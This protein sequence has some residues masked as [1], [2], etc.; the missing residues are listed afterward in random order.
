MTAAA[1]VRAFTA[2]GGDF[3]YG[4]VLD[5]FLRHGKHHVPP[6]LLDA[7]AGCPFDPVLVDVLLD[8]FDKRYDY[9]SYLA[10]PLLDRAEGDRDRLVA[11][12]LD[13]AIAFEE[14]PGSRLPDL[15]PA[16]T[17]KRVRHLR[18][19]RPAL[20]VTP[21]PAERLLLRCT[22]LPVATVHDE[23]LFIRVL[24]AFELTFAQIVTDLSAFSP[25]AL[26]LAADRLRSRG[27]LWSALA[28]MSVEAFQRFRRYT[29]GASAIQ[30]RHYKLMESLAR[31]PDA[32]RLASEAYL[33]VPEVRVRVLAGGPT[34]DAVLTP[35]RATHAA[36]TDFAE[37]LTQWRR[38]H[39]RV[40]VRMLGPDRPGTGYTAGPSY[41]AEAR[42][43]PVF[44]GCPFRE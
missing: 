32:A 11:L 28:T 4:P 31:R 13:D 18:R 26:H 40:A 10:L 16:D 24:Q 42:A 41:L 30:S 9:R 3:P 38:T 27:P 35:D 2:S 5:E 20:D 25:E 36:M 39:Y 22:M 1:A 6:D 21:T 12:L 29:E 19:A 43:I 7:L 23:H 34:I 15:R 14:A 8:K 37:A 17:A 33:S 44:T